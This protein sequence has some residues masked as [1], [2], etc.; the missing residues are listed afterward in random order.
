MAKC[1]K[2]N[3]VMAAGKFDKLTGPGNFSID[4]ESAKVLIC[5]NC[6]YVKLPGE[7]GQKG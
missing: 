3:R 7:K 4:L 6:G 2:C 1:P 5:E